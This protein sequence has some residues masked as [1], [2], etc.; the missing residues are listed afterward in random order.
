[1]SPALL[2]RLNAMLNDER[3][4]AE[5]QKAIYSE[6]KVKLSNAALSRY[7][8]RREVPKEMQP[9]PAT[10]V[11]GRDG[12]AAGAPA[13]ILITVSGPVKLTIIC[14]G[15]AEVLQNL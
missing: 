4:Y 7:Y 9:V 5:I 15:T 13:E 8:H 2:A 6:F 1:M 11:V 14:N 12:K 3:S 10:S